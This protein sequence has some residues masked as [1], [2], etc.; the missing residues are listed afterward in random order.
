MTQ[1]YSGLVHLNGNLLC[2]VDLETTGRRAGYH[3]PIQIAVVPLDS[4]LRPL[5]GV[6]PFYQTIRPIHPERAEKQACYVH[7]IP[8]SELMVDAPS[9]EKVEDMLIE[10]YERLDLPFGKTIV[11][12]AHNWAFECKFLQAWLGV[13]LA[14]KMFH[15]HARDA[16]LY[17]AT[18]NDRAAFMG[19]S[20]PFNSLGLESLCRKF[21]IVNQQS[22]DALCDAL[23]EAE[24]YRALLHYEI[25]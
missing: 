7:G 3:E 18:L 10:W 19:L 11:P 8:L 25:V 12:L 13:D 5:E 6:S 20:P 14:D 23:A 1:T 24:V 17:A 21:N 4:N 16:M 2:S 9:P 15:G 22:H